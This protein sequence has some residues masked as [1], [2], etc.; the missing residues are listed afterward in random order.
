MIFKTSFLSTAA[1]NTG[2][3]LIVLLVIGSGC[4]KYTTFATKSQ[5]L[6]SVVLGSEQNV[7]PPASPGLLYSPDE[8]LSYMRK[9]EGGYNVWF[10]ADLGK[11]AALQFGDHAR[12]GGLSLLGSKYRGPH[13]GHIP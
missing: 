4:T 8:H 7:I 10:A 2:S 12:R 13:S 1:R 5:T 9:P 3:A 11:P 6:F